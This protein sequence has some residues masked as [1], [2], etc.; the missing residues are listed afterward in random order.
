MGYWNK[1]RVDFPEAFD[2]QAKMER[3]LGTTVLRVEGQKTP[4]GKRTSLPLYLD[5]LDPMR[6]NYASEPSIKCGIICEGATT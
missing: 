6:G 2:W 4:E 1:I 3:Q 5:E